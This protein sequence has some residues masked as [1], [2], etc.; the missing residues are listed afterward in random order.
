MKHHSKTNQFILTFIITSVIVLLFIWFTV[1]GSEKFKYTEFQTSQPTV[2]NPDPILNNYKSPTYDGYDYAQ[3]Y[4]RPRYAGDAV[5]KPNLSSSSFMIPTRTGKNSN[6]EPYA[7][8]PSVAT[9]QDGTYSI[10]N[11]DGNMM[12]SSETFTPV[13]C[14]SFKYNRTV[15]SEKDKKAGWKLQLVSKG[16]YI[17]KK[18]DGMECLYASIGDSL[19]SYQLSDGCKAKNVCG[20]ESLNYEKELDPY[21]KRTYFEIWNYPEGYAL[22]NVENKKFVCIVNNKSTFSNSVTPNCLFKIEKMD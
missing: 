14:T 1:R 3:P 16:I 15:P 19:R 8:V 6:I 4:A 22:R 2:T 10:K 13:Q 11:I 9:F 12:L 5:G 17:I 18:P 21:S 20:L 7:S